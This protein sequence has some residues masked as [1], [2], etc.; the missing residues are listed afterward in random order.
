VYGELVFN[1]EYFYGKEYISKN[2]VAIDVDKT[3]ELNKLFIHKSDSIFAKYYSIY[4]ETVD[5]WDMTM[6]LHEKNYEFIDNEIKEF[7]KPEYAELKGKFK[8]KI[9]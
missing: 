8:N 6:P 4:F 3:I 7:L 1:Y 2:L 9:K 5:G